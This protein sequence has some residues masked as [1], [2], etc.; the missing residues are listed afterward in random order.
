V[1]LQDAVVALPV[2]IPLCCS[3]PMLPH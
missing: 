2:P 3:Q 1:L